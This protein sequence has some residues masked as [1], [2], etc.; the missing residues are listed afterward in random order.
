M[1]IQS[2]R[3]SESGRNSLLTLKRRT[4]ISTWN[5]LCRWSFCISLADPTP[6]REQVQHHTTAIEMT[7]HTFAGEYSDIYMA[8]LKQRCHH[9]GLEINEKILNEQLK[10]HIHRGIGYLAG[11]QHLKS[12]SDLIQ[13]TI[14]CK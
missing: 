13:K 7:W 3:I 14:K 12:I 2:V 4:G 11:D 8:A 1:N 10:L 5:T 6:P 9:D